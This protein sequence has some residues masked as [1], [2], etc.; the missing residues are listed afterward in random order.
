MSF[1]GRPGGR[2]ADGPSPDIVWAWCPRLPRCCGLRKCARGFV[3]E[4]LSRWPQRPG[5][6]PVAGVPSGGSRGHVASPEVKGRARRCSGDGKRPGSEPPPG[7]ARSAP[8]APRVPGPPHALQP[9]CGLKPRVWLSDLIF[10]AGH[11]SLANWPRLYPGHLG[12]LRSTG[13]RQLHLCQEGRPP[14]PAP[15][16]RTGDL[17]LGPDS[18]SGAKSIELGNGQRTQ[19]SEGRGRATLSPTP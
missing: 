12:A 3:P 6:P 11:R 4:V 17:V 14:Q 9:Q 19:R 7:A 2:A 8:G 10:P 15:L 13:L 16:Q 18:W 1:P 5:L